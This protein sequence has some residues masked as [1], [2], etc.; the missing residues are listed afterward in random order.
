MWCLIALAILP[1]TGSSAFPASPAGCNGCKNAEVHLHKASARFMHMPRKEHRPPLH[2]SFVAALIQAEPLSAST[3][4]RIGSSD[5]DNWRAVTKSF[6]V[7]SVAELFDKTWFVALLC[8]LRYGV[9]TS[10]FASYIALALHTLIAAG[11]GIAISGFFSLALLN[12]TTAG[13]F[14]VIA[15]FYAYEWYHSDSASN[16]LEERSNEA[17]D[18]LDEDNKAPGLFGLSLQSCFWRVF[19][20]V[21]IAEWGD[22]T[23]I[24]MISC[25]SSMPVWPV[26]FGSLMAFLMLTIMAVLVAKMLEGKKLSERFISGVSAVSFGIFAIIALLDGLKEMPST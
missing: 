19:L 17:R 25:H 21:F 5:M 2:D 7:V 20:A 9:W 23:Q 10:V 14:S 3:E 12:F 15:I 11:M 16:A 18:A 24:A 13:V 22:R 26:C 4:K 1:A 8:S 6:C